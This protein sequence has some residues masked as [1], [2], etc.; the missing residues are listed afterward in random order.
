MAATPL[1][2]GVSM[3]GGQKK[4][5]FPERHRHARCPSPIY[6]AYLVKKFNLK[7]L[8]ASGPGTNRQ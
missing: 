3:A 1:P 8:A 6:F 4:R 2:V 5:P 7:I